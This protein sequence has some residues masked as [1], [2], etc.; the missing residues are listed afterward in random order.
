MTKGK[1]T[2]HNSLKRIGCIIG[3]LGIPYVVLWWFEMILLRDKGMN[4]FDRLRMIAPWANSSIL[5]LFHYLVWML[6]ELA[7]YI[8]NLILQRREARSGEQAET[9]SGSAAVRHTDER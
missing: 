5:G 7:Q 9:H 2:I 4:P 1:W 8:T 6:F 3:C